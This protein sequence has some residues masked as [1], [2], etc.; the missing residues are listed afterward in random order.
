MN[1]SWLIFR[2][3]L[4]HCQ[5]RNAKCSKLLIGF[6][7]EEYHLQAW[8]HLL[9]FSA[10]VCCLNQDNI[11]ITWYF[12]VIND[13]AFSKA[14]GKAESD[15]FKEVINTL[16]KQPTQHF[17]IVNFYKIDITFIEYILAIFYAFLHLIFLNRINW[18]IKKFLLASILHWGVFL[19]L[20][21]Q[22]KLLFITYGSISMIF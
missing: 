18:P 2:L 10:S 9:L 20:T 4:N 11:L 7:L 17:N 12:Q 1:Y 8:Q 13:S 14:G 5:A 22:E 19:F 16:T 15:H 3:K 6:S 21:Q